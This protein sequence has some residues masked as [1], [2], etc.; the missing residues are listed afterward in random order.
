VP[1]ALRRYSFV[2]QRL[3]QLY[4]IIFDTTYASDLID[5]GYEDVWQ[6]LSC[7]QNRRN[8]F[9]HGIP[10]A[11]D[12]ALVRSVVQMLKREHLAWI[13]VFNRRVGRPSSN[14]A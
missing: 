1:T 9:A 6:Q 8:D 4:R 11:I 2:G 5:L 13:A 14:Q 3:D 12:D 10:Q 7:L